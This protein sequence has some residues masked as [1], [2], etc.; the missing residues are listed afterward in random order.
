M[1]P[2]FFSDPVSK[3]PG[4][5]PVESGFYKEWFLLAAATKRQNKLMA[6]KL[7]LYR[8]LRGSGIPKSAV[9]QYMEATQGPAKPTPWLAR[10]GL[11]GAPNIV[12][13]G[14]A[15]VFIAAAIMRRRK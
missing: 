15:G 12:P 14:I 8:E 1:A 13:L 6:R 4:V 5:Y 3:G 9:Q 10:P 11:F 7:E 2:T